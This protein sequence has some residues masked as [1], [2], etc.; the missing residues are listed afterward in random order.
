MGGIISVKEKVGIKV[1]PK[2]YNEE[3]FKLIIEIFNKLDSNNNLIL[4]LDEMKNISNKYIEYR[5]N[6]LK[7]NKSGKNI[8]KDELLNKLK[9]KRDERIEKTGIDYNLKKNKIEN[10]YNNNIKQIDNKI[11]YYNKMDEIERCKTFMEMISY[12]NK[13]IDFWKF[14]TYMKDKDELIKENR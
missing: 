4:E 2:D 14:F 7:D 3:R 12:N 9:L 8:S 11:E 6:F 13:D 5:I 1:C 10:E